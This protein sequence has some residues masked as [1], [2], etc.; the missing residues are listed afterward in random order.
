VIKNKRGFTLIELMVAVAIIVLI[1]TG[2]LLSFTHL[3]FLADTSNNLTVAVS[4]AQNVLEQIKLAAYVNYNSISTYVAPTLNNLP[5]ELITL[6]RSVGA[7]LATV[8][9]NVR[10]FEKNNEINYSLS[11]CIARE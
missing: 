3:M 8:T 4:D 1:V 2:S 5:N 10:W 7:N 6:T 9:V 11:T